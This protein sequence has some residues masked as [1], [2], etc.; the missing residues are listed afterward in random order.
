MHEG[1]KNA[2]WDLMG[3]HEGKRPLGTPTCR[4][5][6]NIKWTLLK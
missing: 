1:K 3:K 5:K 2:Y 4:W 6:D